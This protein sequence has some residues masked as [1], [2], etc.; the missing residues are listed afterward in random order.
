MPV[1]LVASMKSNKLGVDELLLCQAKFP[2]TW[3]LALIVSLI[4]ELMLVWL[5][6]PTIGAW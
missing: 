6:M 3:F 2:D 1:I 5:L 4:R